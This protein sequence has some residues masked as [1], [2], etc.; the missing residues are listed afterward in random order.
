MRPRLFYVIFDSGK[1]IAIRKGA[2]E[3]RKLSPHR[4]YKPFKSELEAEEFA[5]WFNYTS[6]TARTAV[7][8]PRR[9]L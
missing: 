2:T 6:T 3:A 9:P 8:L 5:A 7:D 1:V 4:A